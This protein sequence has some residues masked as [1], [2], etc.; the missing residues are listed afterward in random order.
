MPCFLEYERNPYE[1]KLFLQNR[2]Y[3]EAEVPV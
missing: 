1:V 3:E 2:I